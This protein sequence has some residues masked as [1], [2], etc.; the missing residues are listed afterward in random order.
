MFTKVK[1][2]IVH[3][4]ILNL[5][6]EPRMVDLKLISLKEL[7]QTF[8]HV[9]AWSCQVKQNHY[10]N[11][12]N[13]C[14]NRKKFGGKN[15]APRIFSDWRFSEC[16]FSEVV[17]ILTIPY[18]LVIIPTFSGK[19]LA[20]KYIWCFKDVVMKNYNGGGLKGHAMSHGACSNACKKV[21]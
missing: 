6:L 5:F 20:S 3:T 16:H 14:W 12:L 10:G 13:I 9:W 15:L 11:S 21:Y 17:I 1:R 19:I 8:L 2:R 4:H 7:K 18:K